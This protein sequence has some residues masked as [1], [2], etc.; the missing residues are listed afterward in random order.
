MTATDFGF[1]ITAFLSVWT[2]AAVVISKNP[3]RAALFL[4]LNFVCL[5]ALYLLLNAQ[6]LAALQILVYAGAIMVLFL[7]VIML[8][9]LGGEQ[10]LQDPLAGQKGA[11]LLLGA[12]LLFGL[13][14][15][16]RSAMAMEPAVRANVQAPQ[17]AYGDQV[18]DIGMSLMT[19]YLYP[20]ELTS[21][22]LLVGIV[23]VVLL[24]RRTVAE[25]RQQRGGS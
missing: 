3:V 17:G 8:L 16:V 24:A 22:L 7:F 15:A 5:A 9:N 2:G 19:E 12:V 10:S 23:G 21:V 14:A 25:E 6:L 1:W 4:V 11:A 18:R 13:G 20:F